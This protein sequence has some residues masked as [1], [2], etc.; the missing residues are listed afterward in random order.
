MVDGWT[1]SP[2]FLRSGDR[3]LL[4]DDIFDS[5]RTINHL[6]EIFLETGIPRSDIKVAVH[7][8][9]IRS[10]IEDRLPIQP[11]YWCR[12]HDVTS[13]EN[14]NWIHYLSHELVGLTEDEISEY[15]SDDAEVRA[16]IAEVSS[17]SE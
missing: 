7:D 10:F 17:A 6:V 1:Y 9:K 11:D 15:Y 12:R 2:E 16:A 13:P 3:I 8:Y 5:G 4:I 14:D